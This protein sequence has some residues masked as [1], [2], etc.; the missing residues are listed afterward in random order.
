M[1]DIDDS[2]SSSLSWLVI[3]GLAS[4][5][6]CH[7]WQSVPMGR[8][9]H[10]YQHCKQSMITNSLPTSQFWYHEQC[11]PAKTQE[12]GHGWFTHAWPNSQQFSI[13]T[14]NI[15]CNRKLWLEEDDTHPKLVTRKTK[16]AVLSFDSQHSNLVPN[17]S[18]CRSS[19]ITNIFVV[20]LVLSWHV[21]A[22][23]WFSL[24]MPCSV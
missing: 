17:C 20:C 3:L 23:R 5:L 2:D 22:Y 13:I 1:T 21:V 8:S 7:F 18:L 16:A 19:F 6:D 12:K 10:N 24:L 4:R 15:S 9:R 11:T 14:I